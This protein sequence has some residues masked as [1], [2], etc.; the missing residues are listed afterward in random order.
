MPAKRASVPDSADTTTQAGRDIHPIAP[1]SAAPK[2]T[3]RP[4]LRLALILV[5]SFMV[6]L[7]FTIVN[8]ALPSMERDFGVAIPVVQWVVTGY[9]IA[10][11][12]LLILGGR[13]ADMLGRRRIFIVGLVVFSLASLAGGLAGDPMLLVASRIAQGAGAALVAPAALSLI[14]TSFPPGPRRTRAIGLYG[15]MASV[16]FVAGQVLGGVLV[17]WTSWRAV[18]LVNVPVGLTAAFLAP[19]LIAVSAQRPRAPRHRGKRLDVRGA[20]LITAAVTLAVFGIS[21]GDVFGWTSPLVL[22]AAV[23]AV[24]A[25][26]C[27]V[28]AET[29]H[30]APLVQPKLLLRPGLRDGATLAFL[31]G[32]WNGGQLLVLS[33]YMQQ[34]LHFSPLVTGL[35]IAPQGMA[36]FSMGMLGPRLASRF[37][38]RRVAMIAGL[39]ATVGFAALTQLPAVGYSPLLFVVILVGFGSAGTAF[40]SIV[41]ASRALSDGDQ[42]L[43]GG[44]V[45]TSRQV[46]AA[47]GAALLPAVAES[48]SGVS[49]DRAAML[50]ATVAALAATAVSWRAARQAT[51]PPPPDPPAV[52]Q[53]A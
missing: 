9:A 25:A 49:G 23:L 24:A 26:A 34:V 19:R 40:G 41:L 20:V 47:V 37:G 50:T 18:F 12:G 21:Q 27:F 22:G 16:G 15:S 33:L 2:D 53:I 42:G 1:H 30:P 3:G 32:V 35:I 4:G 36:G 14:T 13:A 46:G 39:S 28:V 31:L 5:A 6:V 8:I 43:A 17:E 51:P 10:F 52:P 38:I 29:R 44:V 7:D 48:I 11:G 45:N